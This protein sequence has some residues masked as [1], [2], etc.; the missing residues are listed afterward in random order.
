MGEFQFQNRRDFI[1]YVFGASAL[2]S[3][4][5]LLSNEN[6]KRKG[7]HKI[8]LLYTNDLHSRID[9]FPKNDPKYPD[10]GGF[11]RRAA[12]IK[13]IKSEEENVLVL[14]AGDVFQGTPY[15][16]LYKGE[17]EYKLLSKMGYDCITIGNH[18]F[19]LGIENISNQLPHASFELISAN[20]NFTNTALEG[21]I[22]PYKIFN[23]S[24]IKIGVFGLGIELEGLVGKKL[25]EET[26]YFNPILVTKDMVNT[27]KKEEKCDLVICLSHLG[28]KSDEKKINDQILASETE[29]IDLIIGGHTHT[30]LDTPLEIKNKSSY[31]TRVTQMGWGGI[32]MGRYDIFFDENRRK[33]L[34]SAQALDVGENLKRRI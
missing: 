16:N 5:P 8:T 28:F 22:K 26:K 6:L 23:K 11:A 2:I 31:P 25:F 9:P 29:G 27:L 14:D 24:G 12:L 34:H 13:K 17:L 15:F 18:D 20:Y 1:K 10:K 3:G 33:Q 7:F 19:D 32:W 4:F 30:F 21:K